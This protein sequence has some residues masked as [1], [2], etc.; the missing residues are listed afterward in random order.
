MTQ[1]K[2]VNVFMISKLVQTLS[3]TELSQDFAVY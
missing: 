3:N 1:T 2:G